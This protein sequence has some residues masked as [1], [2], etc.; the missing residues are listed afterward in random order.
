MSFRNLS[1]IVNIALG[2]L[3]GG[4][5]GVQA[6]A[7]QQ[8][9]RLTAQV[10]TSGKIPKDQANYLPFPLPPAGYIYDCSHC[11]FWQEPNRCRIVG[12]PS[13][14][15]S[16]ETVQPWHYCTLWLPPGGEPVLGWLFPG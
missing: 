13:D 16:G 3:T 6:A 4:N 12:L 5:A 14:P 10:A 2:F 9:L 8:E 7:D 11:R 15:W 1:P